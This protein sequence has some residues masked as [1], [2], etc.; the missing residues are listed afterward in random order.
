MHLSWLARKFAPDPIQV[1]P[2]RGAA[3]C[4]ATKQEQIMIAYPERKHW[5]GCQKGS[6]HLFCWL[7]CGKY[8]CPYTQCK[9]EK[10]AETYFY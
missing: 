8:Y 9:N 5:T 4:L 3:A 6:K 7:I 10:Y 2:V 1:K